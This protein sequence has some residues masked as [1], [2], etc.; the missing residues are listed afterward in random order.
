MF[1]LG[2]YYKTKPQTSPTMSQ[3]DDSELLVQVDKKKK[4]T[5]KKRIVFSVF[6]L[7]IRPIKLGFSFK[8]LKIAVLFLNSQPTDSQ[9]GVITITPT[10]PTVSGLNTIYTI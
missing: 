2:S 10:E 8:K 5:N 3:N 7:K 1:A 9:S 6:V 4:F